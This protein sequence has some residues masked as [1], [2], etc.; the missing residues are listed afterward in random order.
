[1]SSLVSSTYLS[2][3]PSGRVMPSGARLASNTSL[4][5]D[6]SSGPVIN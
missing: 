6:T 4:G 3:V 2:G 5:A 1:M